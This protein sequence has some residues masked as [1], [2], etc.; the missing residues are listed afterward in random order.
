[1]TEQDVEI[2]LQKAR[3]NFPGV[4]PRIISDN[5]SQF[6]SKEFKQFIVQVAMS[7]TTISPNYP[8]SN[9]KLE[10]CNKTI[11]DY[12]KTMYI[13]DLEDGCRLIG[14]FINYYNDIRLH[15]AIGYVAP[16][17]KLNGQEQRIFQQREEKLQSARF[18]RQSLRQ[19]ISNSNRLTLL[20]ICL[21]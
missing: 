7:H 9:G 10:R 18:Q 19:S 11:K 20:K 5:G 8:Q 3:E 21:T 1:M 17:V 12:L 4:K 13:V 6:I 16:K 14:E 2:A 15:S